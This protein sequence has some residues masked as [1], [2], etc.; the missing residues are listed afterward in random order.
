MLMGVRWRQVDTEVISIL[1]WLSSGPV[2]QA[3]CHPC[4]ESGSTGW[5]NL[6]LSPTLLLQCL[7]TGGYQGQC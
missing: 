7:M 1:T 6:E 5:W 2:L 3:H 4:G